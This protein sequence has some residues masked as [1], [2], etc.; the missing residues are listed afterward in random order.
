M[1]L[2]LTSIHIENFKG[3][4]SQDVTFSDKTRICGAN[5]TGKTTVF[6][7]VTWLLFNKNSLGAEKFDLR[8]IDKDGNRVYHVEIYVSAEI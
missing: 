8:P 4:K 6:D 3:V 2:K 5:A 1:E 7:A